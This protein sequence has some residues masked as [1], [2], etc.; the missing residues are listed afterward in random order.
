MFDRRL[1]MLG[2]VST[3][4]ATLLQTVK[5]FCVRNRLDIKKYEMRSDGYPRIEGMTGPMVFEVD[6]RK[7][8]T[9]NGYA[10]NIHT[11]R[12]VIPIP[13]GGQIFV[14]HD[15]GRVTSISS[16]LPLRTLNFAEVM[17]LAKQ[18]DHNITSLGYGEPRWERRNRTEDDFHEQVKFGNGLYANWQIDGEWVLELRIRAYSSFSHVAFTTP[19]GSP[20]DA[21]KEP[22]S[23]LLDFYMVV[24]DPIVDEMRQLKW[25]RRLALTGSKDG[26][27]PVKIWF[28]DPDWRPPNWQGTWIK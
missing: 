9:P 28:D 17:A 14:S 5:G 22:E 13:A 10:I 25:A 19:I 27:F 15:I 1:P 12:G 26:M 18:I 4:E 8:G 6:P 24:D 21:T 20:P 3:L 11:K 16:M 7:R 23:Y 2:P